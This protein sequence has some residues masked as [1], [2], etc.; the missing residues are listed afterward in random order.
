MT[1]GRARLTL[2]PAALL[3]IAA[4]SLHAQEVSAF[5]P[6]Y[7]LVS[8]QAV[9]S[10]QSDIP[11][12]CPDGSVCV[13]NLS[14]GS[15]AH[16]KTLAGPDLG[17]KFGAAIVTHLRLRDQ[18]M[19]MIVENRSDGSKFV[20]SF[21]RA[22]QTGGQTCISRLDVDQLDFHPSGAGIDVNYLDICATTPPVFPSTE[23]VD[24]RASTISPADFRRKKGG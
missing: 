24:V 2:C 5:R 1:A 9:D 8:A 14:F 19:L 17:E 16:S 18:P 12:D 15:F 6:T 22:S 7:S 21:T 10:V 3:A 20:R 13:D 11:L 4:A 23:V